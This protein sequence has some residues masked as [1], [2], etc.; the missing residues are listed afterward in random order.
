MFSCEVN[1]YFKASWCNLQ[2]NNSGKCKINTTATPQVSFRASQTESYRKV[3]KA[4][5]DTCKLI[6]FVALFPLFIIT[7]VI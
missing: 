1:P 6:R 7:A 5:V 2:V 4:Q 3:T